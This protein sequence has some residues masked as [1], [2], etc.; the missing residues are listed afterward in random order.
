[1]QIFEKIANFS[2]NREIL[3]LNRDKLRRELAQP[4][5]QGQADIRELTE[6][7]FR[8]QVHI[9]EAEYIY[10]RIENHLRDNPIRI[11]EI[12]VAYVREL[13][14]KIEEEK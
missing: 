2:L 6:D 7:S 10:D 13:P 11:R 4:L 1:M 3:K 9:R 14:K 12:E 8:Q 5:G